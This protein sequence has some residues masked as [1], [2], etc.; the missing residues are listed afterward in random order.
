MTR[1]SVD[2]RMRKLVY[3]LFFVGNSCPTWAKKA[4]H[5]PYTIV[6]AMLVFFVDFIAG[7]LQQVFEVEYHGFECPSTTIANVSEV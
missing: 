6:V 5:Q 2:K 7:F 1:M 3:V 4:H